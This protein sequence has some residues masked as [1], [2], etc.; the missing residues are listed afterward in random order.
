MEDNTLKVK[1]LIVEDVAIT[2]M[3]ISIGLS[4]SGYQ[5]VGIAPTA[6]RAQQLLLENPSVDIILIDIV[7]KGG[8][9][10]IELA[11]FINEKHQIPFVFLT[12]HADSHL[13]ERAK[14][15]RPYGYI[16][17]P[18]NARQVSIA[19]EFALVNISNKTPAK[20]LLAPQKFSHADNQVLQIKD[21]LFLKKDHH[22]ERV[23]LKEILFLEADSNYSTVYTKSKQFVYSTVLKK[24]ESQLPMNRFLRIHRRYVVN[25]ELVNGFEGNMLFI[26]SKKLPVSKAHKNEVFRLFRTI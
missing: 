12:S 21:S 15:V 3:D 17:K 10:G 7:L 26:G 19:I 22:F 23:P 14:D 5:I 8:L 18:F 9:D 6:Y 16:L 11:R 20:D 25:I 4:E 1:V 13:V 2:A 24:I